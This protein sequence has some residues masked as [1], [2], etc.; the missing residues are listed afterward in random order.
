[1]LSWRPKAR[2]GVVGVVLIFEAR[3]WENFRHLGGASTSFISL[4]D[5]AMT[6]RLG[7]W[8]CAADFWFVSRQRQGDLDQLRLDF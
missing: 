5:P 4:P 8:H 6:L 1:M 7:M 2:A 3:G